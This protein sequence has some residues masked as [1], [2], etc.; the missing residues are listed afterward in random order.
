MCLPG[1]YGEM[2]LSKIPFILLATWGNYVTYSP[3]NPPAPEHVCYPSSLTVPLE[4][5]RFLQWAL[6]ICKVSNCS[7]DILA[8]KT[9]KRPSDRSHNSSFPLSRYQPSWHLRTLHRLYPNYYCQCSSGTVAIQKTFT[10]QT[11]LR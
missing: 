5:S 3:P 10:C 2:S 6:T 11:P 7:E 4:N 8:E 1:C 9:T